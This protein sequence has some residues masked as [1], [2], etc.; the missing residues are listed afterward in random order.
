ML[1]SSDVPAHLDRWR[2]TNGRCGGARRGSGTWSS[3]G[4][5]RPWRCSSSEHT[6]GSSSTLA[7]VALALLCVVLDQ[8]RAAAEMSALRSAGSAANGES[9]GIE[10]GGRSLSRPENEIGLLR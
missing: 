7:A 3:A 6:P 4:L 9:G 2:K 10:P 1:E 8:S 5:Q